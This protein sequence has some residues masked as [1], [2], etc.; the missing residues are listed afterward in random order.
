M[1]QQDNERMNR[2]RAFSDMAELARRNGNAVAQ[3]Y[4]RGFSLAA[5][6]GDQR[7]ALRCMEEAARH[8]HVEAMYD[9]GLLAGEMGDANLARFWWEAAAGAGHGKAAKNI[10]VTEFRAGR[11]DAAGL[12]FHKAAERGVPS[13]YAGLAQLANHVGD[14]AAELSWAGPRGGGR[15]VLPDAVWPGHAEPPRRQPASGASRAA[16]P[17]TGGRT[18]R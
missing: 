7:E 15:P 5:L 11:L 16:V 9:A 6:G 17:A 3:L 8:G 14:Q 12:W 13:G 18:R 4:L 10:A 1:A 2:L